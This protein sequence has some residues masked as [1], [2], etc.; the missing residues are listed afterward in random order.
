MKIPERN[1]SAVASFGLRTFNSLQNPVYR[2]Y[3]LGV[4]GQFASMSMQMVTSSLLIYRLTDSSALLGTQALAN[5]IPMLL[6]SLFGGALADRIQKKQVLMIGLIFS[7]I[8]SL[9]V[10]LSISTGHLSRE[11][12]GSWWILMVSSFAQG[13]VMGMM[14]PA[15]MAIIPEIVSKEQTMNAVALNM[16]GMNVLSLLAP[17]A[18]GFLIDAKGFD[19]V[20]YTMTALNFYGAVMIFFVPRTGRLSNRTG[21]IMADIR[22]GFRYMRTDRR[23]LLLL[24]FTLLFVTFS[25]PYQQLLP[26]YVDDILKVGAK[27]MGILLSVSGAGALVASIALASLPNKKRGLMLLIGG[28]ISGVALLGFAF[29]KVW[30]LSL[31]FIVFVG[32]SQTIRG[33]TGNSLLQTYTEPGYMGR[34]MSIFMMQWGIMSLCTFF[35]GVIAEVAP[36]QWVIGSLAIAL[37]AVSVL[38][39]F[40]VPRIRRLD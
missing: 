6:V 21:N 10:A 33:T 23:I 32:L 16:L 17:A 7:G 8:I 4:L 40:V 24:V 27:G 13:I 12:T 25:M 9:W 30:G 29:S 34:V 31:A 3:F 20:Y 14:L 22:D 28:I 39:M 11:I 5:A 18:A 38:A 15:R 19:A 37:I 36:V 2:T 26:I 1:R 35:A